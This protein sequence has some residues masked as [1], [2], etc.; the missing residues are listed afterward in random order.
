MFWFRYLNYN[1]IG[2]FPMESQFLDFILRTELEFEIIKLSSETPRR[3]LYNESR[4]RHTLAHTSC[5][6][7]R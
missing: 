4:G 1:E 7:C 3:N 2:L 5:A 6:R